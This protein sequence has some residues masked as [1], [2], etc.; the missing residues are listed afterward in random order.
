LFV[1]D[2]ATLLQSPT[3]ANIL[4]TKENPIY[5]EGKLDAARWFQNVE[6]LA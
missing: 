2:L 5:W 3:D 6:E 1:V 4:V